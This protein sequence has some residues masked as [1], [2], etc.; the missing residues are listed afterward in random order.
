MKKLWRNANF[1][2][3]ICI[4]V[5]LLIFAIGVTAINIHKTRVNKEAREGDS[6]YYFDPEA[7][8]VDPNASSENSETQE[9]SGSPSSTSD[10]ND[11]SHSSEETSQASESSSAPESSEQS[12]SSESSD[13]SESSEESESSESSEESESSESS[14]SSGETESSGPDLSGLTDYLLRVNKATNVITVFTYDENGEYTIPVKAMICSTGP[15]TPEGSF[16]MSY[17]ASINELILDEWGMYVAH[18]TGDYLF[19][20]VPYLSGSYSGID[21]ASVNVYDY[22]NLGT[23]AS[24][25]CVRITCGDAYWIYCNC[26]AY[27]T[28]IEI[29][30]YDSDPLGKPTAIKLPTD[31]DRNWDPTD[32]SSENPWNDKKPYFTGVAEEITIE[33]GSALPDFE[34]GVTAYDTCY[35]ELWY[36]NVS[37]DVDVNTPGT[38]TVTYSATDAL[39]RTG[40]AYT[41]VIVKPAENSG[42]NS[43]SSGDTGE[44]SGEAGGGSSGESGGESGGGAGESSGNSS[45]SGAQDLG[46][47]TSGS[48]GSGDSSENHSSESSDGEGTE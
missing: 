7:V 23:S 29:G 35:N 37:D 4:I 2:F 12:E 31:S 14:E 17:Q 22:N 10:P 43:D 41:T 8:I 47:Q 24:H 30:W 44:S 18:I 9:S 33:Q 11:S 5:P 27:E 13:S 48:S 40:Y 19:H 21:H 39:G 36:F 1:R 45:D 38:Y 46:G 6:L 32:P 16:T 3:V 28:L 15:N 25:G 34:A 42:D 20:S 26:S